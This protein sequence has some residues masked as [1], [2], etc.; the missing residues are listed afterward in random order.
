MTRSFQVLPASFGLV[1][2]TTTTDAEGQLSTSVFEVGESLWV[3]VGMVGF[4]RI[5]DTNEPDVVIELRVL[6]DKGKPTIEK[7]FSGQ[8]NAKAKVPANARFLPAQFLVLL[9]RPGKFT[10]EVK[11]TFAVCKK[12]VSLSFP[13]NVVETK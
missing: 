3:N 2:L 9:N 5:K 6:D 1:R 10:V 7:P 4:G 13:I 8:I 11:A 12:T